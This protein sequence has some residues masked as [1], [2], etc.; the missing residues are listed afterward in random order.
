M[1]Q[2]VV[3]TAPFAM[4]VSVIAN[5]FTEARALCAMGVIFAS[6]PPQFSLAEPRRVKRLTAL[7]V[8]LQR[9]VFTVVQV[10]RP[11]SFARLAEYI[12]KRA[13]HGLL[14]VNTPP[15]VEHSLRSILLSRL[16]RKSPVLQ[17]R[18]QTRVALFCLLL[19]EAEGLREEFV[20]VRRR[21]GLSLA[22][23]NSP[24]MHI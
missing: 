16:Q 11:S 1:V 8:A 10:I 23:E 6:H 5:A 22:C 12:A 9:R 2:E 15:S 4:V 14:A 7:G 3:F 19:R 24:G 13:R 21:L 20:H 17:R 18:L